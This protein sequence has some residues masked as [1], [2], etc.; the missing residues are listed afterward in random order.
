M[1]LQKAGAVE[2]TRDTEFNSLASSFERTANSTQRLADEVKRYGE[3]IEAQLTHHIGLLQAWQRT[4]QTNSQYQRR[5]GSLIEAA[6][7]C[8]RRLLD[9]WK[10][11]IEVPIIKKLL[12]TLLTAQQG[13]TAKITKRNHKLIDYDRHRTSAKKLSTSEQTRSLSD[14]RRLVKTEQ[15]L[16]QAEDDYIRYNERLKE[17]IPTFL[18][19]HGRLLQPI[20]T[21]LVTFQQH[22]YHEL[23]ALRTIIDGGGRDYSEIL[24]SFEEESSEA[25]LHLRQNPLIQ[26]LTGKPIKSSERGTA[27]S[28]AGVVEITSRLRSRTTSSS[29]SF[30][31]CSSDS[32]GSKEREIVTASKRREEQAKNLA[33]PRQS[34]SAP[35]LVLQ[36]PQRGSSTLGSPAD[37]P[38]RSIERDKFKEAGEKAYL[39]VYAESKSKTTEGDSFY[40]CQEDNNPWRLHK[41][42]LASLGRDSKEKTVASAPSQTA[43]SPSS[44]PPVANE[45]RGSKVAE[46]AAKL[47]GLG[48][49]GAAPA[50]TN[51]NNSSQPLRH[52]PS[53]SVRTSAKD[54]TGKTMA[55]AIYDFLGQEAEDLSFRVGDRVEVLKR[56]AEANDWWTG[57]LNGRRGVFPGTYVRVLE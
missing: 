42:E 56:T 31:S 1:V 54:T 34:Q 50:S 25:L 15:A 6:R 40:D 8:Q 12:P 5:L 2:E 24:S 26:A 30:N 9:K 41:K 46:L 35:P 55:V 44:P 52:S 23:D 14:E 27:A 47:S 4:V 16:D 17:D 37:V 28:T 21:T 13:I 45:R 53:P 43:R 20:L 38:I 49:Q 51:T 32:S 57:V 29:G 19:L 33:P 22:F 3:A 48:L 7:G 18:A 39:E 10:V 36:A 11:T